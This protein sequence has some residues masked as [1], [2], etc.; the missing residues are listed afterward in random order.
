M[1]TVD[2]ST[3][4]N[5]AMT[6]LGTP[7]AHEKHTKGEGV[8][9]INLLLEVWKACHPESAIEYDDRWAFVNSSDDFR[10]EAA[11][12]WQEIPF[13]E[14]KIGDILIFRPYYRGKAV[15]CGMIISRLPSLA[16]GKPD[17]R[18]VIHC[19]NSVGVVAD[20]LPE[21]WVRRCLIAFRF[22]WVTGF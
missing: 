15:H 3:V 4:V 9:C 8:D 21:A 12:Y 10:R 17:N 14:S 6:W 5:E 13:E 11:P 18:R 22:P 2:R 19:Y 1:R 20:D 7:Y 16:Y